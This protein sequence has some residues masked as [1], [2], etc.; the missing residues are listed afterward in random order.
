MFTPVSGVE[1]DG[2]S[3]TGTVNWTFDSG[4]ETFDYLAD[5]EILEIVYTI[6]VTDDNG[7]TVTQDVTITVTGTND[8]PVLDALTASEQ[9]DYARGDG[10]KVVNAT[11]SVTDVDDAMM[12]GA[13]ITI[14]QNYQTGEDSLGF[15]DQ[16]GITGSWDPINGVLTL[17]GPATTANYQAAMQSVTYANNGVPP[18]ASDREVT[19][20]VDDGADISNTVTTTISVS[21]SS[22][23]QGTAGNDTLIGD[24]LDDSSVGLAGYDDIFGGSGNDRLTGGEG[25][26]QLTGGANNDEFVFLETTDGNLEVD[27]VT[28]FTTAD[29][30]INLDDFLAGSNPLAASAAIDVVA[31]TP[32]NSVLRV[33]SVDIVNLTGITAGDIINVVYDDTAAAI[34]VTAA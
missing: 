34:S 8:A 13:T 28:D 12:A 2:S 25:S 6:T 31:T 16:N 7:A 18:T 24:A 33:N 22:N 11:V 27:T 9:L 23:I 19:F 29:D 32:G 30:T 17:S 10:A 14:S 5:S 21:A 20:S 1:I 26:D 15:V 3:T 4:T